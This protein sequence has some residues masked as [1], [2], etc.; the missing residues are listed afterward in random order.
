MVIEDK[1]QQSPSLGSTNEKN[2]PMAMQVGKSQG[3]KGKKPFMQ[4]EYYGLRGH[5][6]ENY[7]KIVGYPEDFKARRKPGNN[8]GGHYGRGNEGQSGFGGGSHQPF[9]AANNVLENTNANS[10]GS[11]SAGDVLGGMTGN[12]PY[13]TEEQYKQILDLLNKDTP[14]IVKSTWQ[15]FTVA[16]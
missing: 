11:S 12:V 3:Y 2:D 14:L 13:F 5:I 8:I 6:K 1:S 10:Q 7:Y 15:T 4:C 9:T 16:G